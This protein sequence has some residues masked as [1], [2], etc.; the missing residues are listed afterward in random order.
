M[1]LIATTP[2]QSARLEASWRAVVRMLGPDAPLEAVL[3]DG[4][5]LSHDPAAPTAAQL[6]ETM[7]AHLGE[8]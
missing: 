5:V 4:R 2:E 1:R 6:I 7:R 3:H 8:A